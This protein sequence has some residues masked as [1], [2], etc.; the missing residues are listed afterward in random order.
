MSTPIE[1][2]ASQ[3]SVYALGDE[4]AEVIIRSAR[5]DLLRE[6]ALKVKEARPLSR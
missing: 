3:P 2:A 5:A 1:P 6:T 4:D